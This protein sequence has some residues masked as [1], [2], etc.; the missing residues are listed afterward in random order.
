MS[1]MT[2]SELKKAWKEFIQDWE[3]KPEKDIR[4]KLKE[5]EYK[6]NKE[7]KVVSDFS[8]PRL[9]T[10]MEKDANP[11][12]MRRLNSEGEIIFTPIS[13]LAIKL[14]YKIGDKTKGKGHGGEKSFFTPQEAKKSKVVVVDQDYIIIPNPYS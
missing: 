9:I 2:N 3:N 13:Q 10:S 14:M 5:T 11:T 8:K 6:I 1:L 4:E 12:V 7:G